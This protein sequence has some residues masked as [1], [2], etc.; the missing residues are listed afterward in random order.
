MEEKKNTVEVN[1][2]QK[3]FSVF[4]FFFLKIHIYMNAFGRRLYPLHSVY[5]H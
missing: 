4:L 2:D 1:R 5:M 3:H